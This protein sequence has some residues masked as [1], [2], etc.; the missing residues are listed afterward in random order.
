VNQPLLFSYILP[1]IEL[2]GGILLIVG[3][4][5]RLISIVFSFILLVAI[6]KVKISA[7]FISNTATGYEF[8]L[9]MLFVSVHAAIITRN[10]FQDNWIQPSPA[11][12][13]LAK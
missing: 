2:I 6:I 7:G 3:F 12:A 9:L 11:N 4:G 13:E 10:S 8:D 5:S 1:W